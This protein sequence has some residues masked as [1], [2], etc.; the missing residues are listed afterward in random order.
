MAEKTG[1]RRR[2]LKGPDE[3]I[4]TFGRT[5]AWCKENR[6]KFA[7]GAIGVVAVVALVLGARAY[8]QMEENRS[9]RELW[10]V[11][12]QAQ[13]ILNAPSAANPSQL[14]S[15]EKSLQETAGRYPKT[16]AA[17]YSLYYLGSIAFHQ[18]NPDLAITRFRAALATGKEAGI[19]KYLLLQ[20]IA[21]S[22]EAKGDY[23]AAASA[24]RDAGAVAD[25]G[26]KTESRMGEARVLALDGKK[27]EAAAL[28]RQIL[29]ENPETPLK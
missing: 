22:L 10:P 12:D 1:L 6:A 5:V 2:D 17:M 9:A 4:S 16:R 26:M 3:F 25:S 15:V 24:Y 13:G 20:G 29:K 14:A 7:A 19:M 23:A 11:L 27:T 28:Y 21:S 8:L 18:G